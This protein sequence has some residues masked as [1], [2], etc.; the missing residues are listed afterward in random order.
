[1]KLNILITAAGGDIGGNIINILSEQKDKELFIVGTDLNKNIFAL[2]KVDRF[3]QVE[4]T[5]SLNYKKQILRIIEENSIIYHRHPHL[6]YFAG[7]IATNPPYAEIDDVIRFG[8]NRGV[9]YWI[10]SSSYVPAMRKQFTALLN[11]AVPHKGL[12][13]VGAHRGRGGYVMILYK[14]KPHD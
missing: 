7:G 5:D 13:L 12:S 9:D 1:M 6:P 10:V 2:D 3:Y 14:I 4:R 11:P 8:R